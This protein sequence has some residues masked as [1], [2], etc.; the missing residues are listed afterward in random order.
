MYEVDGEEDQVPQP[1]HLSKLDA[2]S[3]PA[4]RSKSFA[5]REALP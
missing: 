2:Y 1:P 5:F 4:L 3:I